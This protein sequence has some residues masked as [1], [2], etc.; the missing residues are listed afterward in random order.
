MPEEEEEEPSGQNT[1]SQP[2][3]R[4]KV[5]THPSDTSHWQLWQKYCDT[6]LLFISHKLFKQNLFTL[7]IPVGKEGEERKEEKEGK[8]E[9]QLFI[10]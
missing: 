3:K 6:L 5:P 9:R 7:Y 1:Q 4:K 2:Q 10:W 8:K